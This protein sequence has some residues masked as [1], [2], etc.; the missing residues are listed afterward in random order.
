MSVLRTGRCVCAVGIVSAGV[1]QA[2]GKNCDVGGIWAVA[3]PSYAMVKMLFFSVNLWRGLSA[4][5]ESRSSSL[6]MLELFAFLL[7]LLVIIKLTLVLLRREFLT[8]PR[9]LLLLSVSSASLL[10]LLATPRRCCDGVKLAIELG[11][12][13]ELEL[14]APIRWL[15]MERWRRTDVRLVKNGGSRSNLVLCDGWAFK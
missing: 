1:S 12:E 13:L 3:T 5:P 4:M 11:L 7:L 9:S 6:L 10:P 15:M 2:G 14:A 8:E